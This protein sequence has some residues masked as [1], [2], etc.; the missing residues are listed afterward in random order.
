METYL[1]ISFLN[2]FIFCPRS[3]YYHQIYGSFAKANYQ[4]T[5]QLAGLAAHRTI[6]EKKYSTHKNILQ[7]Y[8]VFSPTYNL[9]GKI[10]LFDIDKGLL[11]ERK[12]EI[13]VIYDGYVFQLY[14]QYFCLIDMGYKINT[15]VLYDISHNKTYPIA[16]PDKD[17][18][19]FEKFIQLLNDI[20]KFNLDDP[21][22]TQNPLKCVR[23]IYNNL[24]DK[25]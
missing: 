7:G 8:E 16:L 13:K 9:V 20:K 10:D 24:C 11:S 18:T 6:D 25:Y 14:A 12:K 23:C 21:T 15:L 3:I 2:D 19:M 22:F 5:P 17:V 1:P 4:Q